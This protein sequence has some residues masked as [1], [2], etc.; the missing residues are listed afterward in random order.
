MPKIIELPEVL[1]NQIAA[2]EVVE[3]QPVLSK[4]WWKMLLMQAAPRLPLKLKNQA[5]QKIQIT[6]NGEGIGS[7]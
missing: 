6:D 2:G 7:S 1:A 5:S 3:R 4:S